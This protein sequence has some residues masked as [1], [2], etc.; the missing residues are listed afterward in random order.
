M[1]QINLNGDIIPNDYK[2]IYEWLEWDATCPN[3]IRN[4]IAEMQPGE[5]LEVFVNSGGGDVQSGQ[6]MYSLLQTVNSTAKIQSFAASAAGVAAMGCK[7]VLISNVGTIMI[8]NVYCGGVAGDYHE[9]DKAS[10]MLKTLN[11]TMA[12]AYAAKSGR[13]LE[14]ILQ[15]MDRETWLSAKGAVEN[16]FA[17]GILGEDDLNITNQKEVIFTNRVAPVQYNN[18]T[19]YGLRL[20]EELKQKVI[21]EAEQKQNDEKLK[22]QLLED[23]DQYGI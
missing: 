4:A 2:W 23:L 8:H 14:E 6:E 7:T 9:M 12:N 15:I 22:N 16:G 20:T 19:A 13:P 18:S 5:E 21:A 3:D 17:D 10:A 11:A 1:A